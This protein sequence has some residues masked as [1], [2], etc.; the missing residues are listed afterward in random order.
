MSQKIK[1][2][3]G[4]ASLGLLV[5]V[6]LLLVELGSQKNRTLA[7]KPDIGG[8]FSLIDQDGR[9][10]SEADFAGSPVLVYFGFTYCPDVCPLSLDILGAALDQLTEMAPAK[11]AALQ[12]VFISVDPARDTPAKMKEYLSYF[13]PK[14]TGLNGSPEQIDEVRKSYRVYSARAPETDANGHYNVDHSSMFYLMD[15]E[16]RY[17]AHFSHNMTAEALA[18]GL[19]EGLAAKLP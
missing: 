2:S 7:S 9:Q 16:N 8:A 14:L 19:A 10:V 6:A 4:I 17:L 13:H 12:P 18:E 1:I 11:A 5:L 15:G 3:L